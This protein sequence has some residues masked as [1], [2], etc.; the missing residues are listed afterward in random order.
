M[1]VEVGL[2]DGTK[3]RLADP[4][5]REDDVVASVRG[6]LAGVVGFRTDAGTYRVLASHV[7][8]VRTVPESDASG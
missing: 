4:N 3:L 5:A 8:Y 7:V 1:P 2:S 6:N